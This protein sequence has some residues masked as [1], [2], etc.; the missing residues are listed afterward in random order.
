MN[1]AVFGTT[2]DEARKLFREAVAKDEELRNRPEPEWGK[3]SS[4]EG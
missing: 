4:I 2:E 1:L 3:N